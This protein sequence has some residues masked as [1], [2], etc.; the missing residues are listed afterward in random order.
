M[1]QRSDEHNIQ[2]S[3]S[4]ARNHISNTI[5]YIDI[6]RYIEYV[7]EDRL[8]SPTENL[9]PGL[10]PTPPGLP[11]TSPGLAAHAGY[12]EPAGDRTLEGERACDSTGAAKPAPTLSVTEPLTGIGGWLGAAW[13][14]AVPDVTTDGPPCLK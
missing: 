10:C 9:S 14:P 5:D 8:N 11:R 7:I 13:L 6:S 12:I 3:Q 1:T 4:L 2:K